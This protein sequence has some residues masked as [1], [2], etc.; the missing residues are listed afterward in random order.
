MTRCPNPARAHHCVYALLDSSYLLQKFLYQEGYSKGIQSAIRRRIKTA[1]TNLSIR[2]LVTGPFETVTTRS[3]S[4]SGQDIDAP[5]SPCRLKENE[6]CLFPVLLDAPNTNLHNMENRHVADVHKLA[7]FVLPLCSKSPL[8]A[9]GITLAILSTALMLDEHEFSPNDQLNGSNGEWTMS[10]DMTSRAKKPVDCPLSA[11]IKVLKLK[12]K[13]LM[14]GSSSEFSP[15]EI[16][17]LRTHKSKYTTWIAKHALT[18]ICDDHKKTSQINGA[19]GEYTGLDDMPKKAMQPKPKK[20]VVAAKSKRSMKPRRQTKTASSSER[21]IVK[22]V[23]PKRQLTPAV[24]TA[25]VDEY[26]YTLLQSHCDSLKFS[27]SFKLP[28]QTGFEAGTILMDTAISMGAFSRLEQSVGKGVLNANI[29]LYMNYIF[30]KIR[31]TNTVITPAGVSGNIAVIFS[32]VEANITSSNVVSWVDAR[33][34]AT[35]FYPGITLFDVGHP[36]NTRTVKNSINGEWLKG[37][38]PVGLTDS[39]SGNASRVGRLVIAVYSPIVVA[40]YAPADGIINPAGWAGP[41]II[42]TIEVSGEWLYRVPQQSISS[43]AYAATQMT[44]NFSGNQIRFDPTGFGDF[45]GGIPSAPTPPDLLAAAVNTVR[46]RQPPTTGL[47][48]AIGSFSDGVGILQLSD[49][50]IIPVVLST[51]Q[52][53]APIIDSGLSLVGLPPI[54]T[55]AVVGGYTLIGLLDTLV[56]NQDIMNSKCKFE[57]S[58]NE[59]NPNGACRVAGGGVAAWNTGF[60]PGVGFASVPASYVNQGIRSQL[61]ALPNDSVGNILFDVTAKLITT[62]GFYTMIVSGD[63][64]TPNKAYEFGDTITAYT[65]EAG[66]QTTLLPSATASWDTSSSTLSGIPLSLADSRILS[67]SFNLIDAP[68]VNP[69]FMLLGNF[70]SGR[71]VD[72]YPNIRVSTAE[73]LTTD[74][75]LD[76]DPLVLATKFVKWF[77]KEPEVDGNLFGC[78]VMVSYG[79]R[80]VWGGFADVTAPLLGSASCGMA[81]LTLVWNSVASELALVQAVELVRRSP[82]GTLVPFPIGLLGDNEVLYSISVDF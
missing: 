57:T 77:N 18:L 63:Y 74:L 78:T 55:M 49:G 53:I 65:S 8:S 23:G 68:R 14:F 71:T 24:S 1:G 59:I 60:T 37:S 56:S 47:P 66:G 22:A 73:S 36:L 21:K 82:A 9:F 25:S 11:R 16:A 6:D 19:N 20:K 29:D 5:K 28:V 3:V 7:T 43:G 4:L 80:G 35:G 75:A 72:F 27:T 34:T 32:P 40:N 64:D 81:E 10:D 76:P 38:R 42:S 58:I 41:D 33:R 54:C 46:T 67:T 17:W 50:S 48:P 39:A 13:I 69:K 62:W 70:P 52:N 15:D 31:L 44:L 45:A 51:I 30:K 12:K 61:S 2:L 26:G 79:A